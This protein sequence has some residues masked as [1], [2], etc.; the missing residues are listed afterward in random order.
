MPDNLNRYRVRNGRRPVDLAS[1]RVVAEPEEISLT[2]EEEKEEHN[3][4]LI[5][6][7]K[8]VFLGKGNV[9]EPSDAAVALA[10]EHNID[11]AEVEGTGKNNRVTKEDVQ[12]FLD[13][14]EQGPNESEEVS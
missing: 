7:G 1:G 12:S 9:L 6:S 13:A 5:D 4:R 3:K 2:P 8:L 14:Q 11:L 10:E